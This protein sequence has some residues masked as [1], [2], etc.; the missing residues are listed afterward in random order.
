MGEII[1]MKNSNKLHISF[2][3]LLL[4]LLVLANGIFGTTFYY[5]IY[6]Q[7]DSTSAQTKLGFS[8]TTFA[9]DSSKT[10]AELMKMAIAGESSTGGKILIEGSA[11][12]NSDCFP[13][14]YFLTL[15]D[16]GGRS[17]IAASFGKNTVQQ[18]LRKQR[19]EVTESI[20]L[21]ARTYLLDKYIYGHYD[22]MLKNITLKH[23][24]VTELS[25]YIPQ[26]M[27][28]TNIR[29]TKDT[30]SFNRVYAELMGEKIIIDLNESDEILSIEFPQRDILAI[31]EKY[32]G[33]EDL[34]TTKV[35]SRE[36]DAGPQFI[37]TNEN[38]KA[39]TELTGLK[40]EISISVDNLTDKLYL[41]TYNQ[42]FQGTVRGTRIE[43]EM[44]IKP[45]AFREGKCYRYPYEIQ[46][47][48]DERF[49]KATKEL[50]ADDAAIKDRATKTA[51][52]AQ[53][54]WQAVRRI[55]LWVSRRIEPTDEQ[56]SVKDA[57]AS[58]KGDAYSQAAL[59][60]T[61]LRAI[62][63]PARVVGGLQYQEG[64]F[65]KHYWVE[66][67]VEEHPGWVQVDPYFSESEKIN[68]G[69]VTLWIGKG[70]IIAKESEITITEYDI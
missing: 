1:F 7:G 30:L 11:R 2:M 70:D 21:P 40:L 14:N 44:T 66:V 59:T 25:V 37:K 23:S 24:I 26:L 31:K 8:K 36:D 13:Q 15:T 57:F 39:Y 16:D 58:E 20:D 64:R 67:W 3:I 17:E 68:A 51:Q 69:H 61:F 38:I 49:L 35:M 33:P 12:Y 43:G 62:G 28:K 6:H 46:I 52:D 56:L 60:V 48:A 47:K 29:L 18:T 41:E 5:S 4:L 42:N 10:T 63:I 55:R 32:G 34:Q 65:N 45:L 27:R 22:I 50:P 53:T 9:N 54:I 19:G